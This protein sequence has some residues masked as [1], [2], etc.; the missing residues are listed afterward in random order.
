MRYMGNK[1]KIADK[2]I[3]FIEKN[4]GESKV[5][6]DLFSGSAATASCFAS[7]YTVVGNDLLYFSKCVTTLYTKVDKN[8]LNNYLR[9]MNNLDGVIGFITINYSPFKTNKRMYFSVEN[10]S[11]I[12]A[13]MIFIKKIENQI[14]R[15]A[16]IG[17]VIESVS[18]VANV[19]GVYG[20]YLKT[21]DKRALKPIIFDYEDSKIYSKDQNVVHNDDANELIKNVT[22]D[23]LYIDPPYT[24]NDYSTQY[25]LLETIAL[26]DEPEIVGITGTRKNKKTSAFTKKI[27][28]EIMFDRLIFNAK[29]KH[30]FVSYSSDGLMSKEFILAVLKR[31]SSNGKVK[32][33]EIP[34]RNYTNHRSISKD[35]LKEY[36]F[37][38]SKNSDAVFSSPMNYMGNKTSLIESIRINAPKEI[39]RAFDVFGGGMNVLLNIKAKKYVYNDN[40]YFVT[41]LLKLFVYEDVK[42]TIFTIEKLISKFQLSKGNKTSFAKIRNA[43]NNTENVDM[44]LLYTT[45][46]FSFNQQIRFNSKMQ[47][48]NTCGES[49]WNESTKEKLISFNQKANSVDLSIMNEDYSDVIQLAEAND[50]VYLDPPYLV[51]TA[52]YNDGKRGF[53][54]WD[55]AQEIELLRK[56]EELNN[57]GVK[58]MLSNVIEHKD[59]ENTHLKQWIKNNGFRVIKLNYKD[60]NEILVVNYE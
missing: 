9:K 22:G 17:V 38:I 14:I 43:F 41:S 35:S 42:S 1:T 53:N 2:I 19:T 4:A 10:A 57:R 55:E 47:Y 27:D 20:A 16:L 30:I 39:E 52:A 44:H 59:K 37:Y 54:G 7:K 25:H 56:I 8:D 50:F 51:T 15:D 40:N 48:N 13:A 31:Y 45:I 26:Y 34:H 58:F 18:K 12:D 49:S 32:T 5:I 24:K 28:A 21:W 23:I 29:Q 46:L 3:D 36:V 6:V 11:K 60:R 33:L